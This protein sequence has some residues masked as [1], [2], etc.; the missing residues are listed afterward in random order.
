VDLALEGISN[1]RKVVA[2][3]LIFGDSFTELK[4][5]MEQV[6]DRCRENQITV[7][8]AKFMIGK[9][10]KFV[11]F[12]IGRNGVSPDPGKIQAII[13]E[14]TELFA[15]TW[16]ELT[17]LQIPIDVWN[18]SRRL[19]QMTMIIKPSKISSLLGRAQ[20]TSKSFIL[21]ILLVPYQKLWDCLSIEGTLIVLD[22]SRIGV[23]RQ[24]R[25]EVLRRLHIPHQG[26]TRTYA[27]AKVV[28]YW[29]G[30]INDINQVIS[31]C[32]LC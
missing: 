23:P 16:K 14:I 24:A 7:S 11:G 3:I 13:L 9:E 27:R 19:L 28:F 32:D 4:L 20:L 2:D 10:V 18:S 1:L 8:E 26:T 31:E 17:D 6:L 12:I 25:G 21:I 5:I 30:M 15:V 29:H 22:G